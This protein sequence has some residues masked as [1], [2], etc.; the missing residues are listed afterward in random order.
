MILLCEMWENYCGKIHFDCSELGF[1]PL[2]IS[3][4]I[5][6]RY[7]IPLPQHMQFSQCDIPSICAKQILSNYPC[8]L[9]LGLPYRE[10]IYPFLQ[11]CPS[12]IS[13]ETDPAIHH[14][15]H[16]PDERARQGEDFCMFLTCRKAGI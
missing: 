7:C 6:L 9:M 13:M 12:G 16:R 8:L 4:N 15:Q 5:S 1:H 2:N 10:E 14:F 3:L 11:C